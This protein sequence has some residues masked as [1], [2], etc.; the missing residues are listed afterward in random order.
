MAW[1][2]AE[3]DPEQAKMEEWVMVNGKREKVKY[4]AVV[5]ARKRLSDKFRKNEHG[6]EKGYNSRN[7]SGP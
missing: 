3:I 5:T 4:I 6:V 7:P 2:L 1:K